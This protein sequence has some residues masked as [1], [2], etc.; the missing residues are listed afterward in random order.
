M[1]K[2]V[3]PYHYAPSAAAAATATAHSP[4]DVAAGAV[5]AVVGVLDGT[6]ETQN[7]GGVAKILPLEPSLSPEAI[8]KKNTLPY[9]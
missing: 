7:R 4:A 3:L 1:P 5:V 6:A 2:L 8:A 9:S